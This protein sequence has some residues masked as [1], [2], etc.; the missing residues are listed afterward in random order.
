MPKPAQRVFSLTRHW[1]TASGTS[2]FVGNSDEVAP[3]VAADPGT[4][5]LSLQQSAL[6]NS[7]TAMTRAERKERAGTDMRLRAHGADAACSMTMTI[8]SS[9][10][11]PL[12]RRHD[13]SQL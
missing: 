3:L 12:A 6:G 11:P 5:A 13:G 10:V 2:K 8:P 1:I 4:V 7:C 9:L